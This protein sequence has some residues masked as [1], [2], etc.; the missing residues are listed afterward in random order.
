MKIMKKI[1]IILS[2]I[3]FSLLFQDISCLNKNEKKLLDAAENG[4]IE[5][6]KSLVSQGVNINIQ[7][8]WGYTPLHLAARNGHIELVKFLTQNP[9]ININAI[10]NYNTTPLHQ[11][12]FMNHHSIVLHLLS[13]PGIDVNIK[14]TDPELTVSSW[15]II[16]FIKY[17][18]EVILHY[19]NFLR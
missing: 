14:K 10:S 8:N 5:L 13:T 17:F 11:A 9:E 15:Y 18:Q 19:S 3:P 2:I 7:N 4:D 12:A 16:K 1:Y 6:I